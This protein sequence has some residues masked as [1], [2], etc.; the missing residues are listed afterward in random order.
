MSFHFRI[1][2]QSLRIP[3]LLSMSGSLQN[4]K[5]F[6]RE[7]AVFDKDYRSLICGRHESH[8]NFLK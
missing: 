3:L 2:V 1:Y 5:A 7:K 4:K 6:D 8:A